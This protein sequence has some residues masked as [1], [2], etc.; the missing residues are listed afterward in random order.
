MKA[1]LRVTGVDPDTMHTVAGHLHR[2]TGDRLREVGCDGPELFSFETPPTGGATLM[3]VLEGIPAFTP[4]GT[5]G[6][7]KD[8]D[9]DLERLLDEEELLEFMFKAQ[10]D[11]LAVLRKIDVEKPWAIYSPLQVGWFDG[12]R[13]WVPLAR[14]RR[15]SE[16]DRRES[17]DLSQPAASAPRL[18]CMSDA[19]WVRVGSQ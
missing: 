5:T 17:V 11:M 16:E 8:C 7:I 14:A 13:G 19:R 18:A 4:A 15:F 1:S 6:F 2:Y 12:E 3:R 9:P 10:D